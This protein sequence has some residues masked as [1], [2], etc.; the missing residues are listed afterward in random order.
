V[1][2]RTDDLT[3]RPLSIGDRIRAWDEGVEDNDPEGEGARKP[4]DAGIML[5][6]A[7]TL[8][9]YAEVIRGEDGAP[10]RLADRMRELH[11]TAEAVLDEG[12]GQEVRTC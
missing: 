11:E 2:R 5:A 8:D 7:D 12:H 3:L 4:F 6:V 1:T 9:A 10:A